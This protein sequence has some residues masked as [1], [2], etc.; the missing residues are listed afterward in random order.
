[1]PSFFQNAIFLFF[2]EKH[3]IRLFCNRKSIAEMWKQQKTIAYKS[4]YLLS[5]QVYDRI[6]KQTS[7]SFGAPMDEVNKM[8]GL[9]ATEN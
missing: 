1:M 8:G 2:P 3:S 9:K 6:G 5:G 7:K 4:F